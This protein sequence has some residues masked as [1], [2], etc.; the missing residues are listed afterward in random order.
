[1]TRADWAALFILWAVLSLPFGVF[2][3]AVLRRGHIPGD[4]EAADLAQ[5]E[6]EAASPPEYEPDDSEAQRI[7][8]LFAEAA[9]EEDRRHD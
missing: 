4:I 5:W 9:A 3:T 1:M 6:H 7:A 8:E 2:T